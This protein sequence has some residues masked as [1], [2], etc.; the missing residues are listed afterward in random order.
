MHNKSRREAMSI[1]C[2]TLAGS[3]VW[4]VTWAAGAGPPAQPPR[5]IEREQAL[6]SRYAYV[7]EDI[8]KI[9]QPARGCWIDLGAG[10]GGVALA[11]IAATGNPV[12]M[13]DPDREALQQ[14]LAQAREGKM[15]DRLLAVVGTAEALPLPDN[16]VDLLAS[17]GSI[18]FW[19]DPVQGLREVHRVLRPGGVAY[20]GGGAGSGYPADAV[21]RLIAERKA[22][23]EGEDAEKWQRFVALRRPAQ[24]REWAEAAGLEGFDVLGSGA[25]SADDPRVGQG[26]W[27]LF[28][29]QP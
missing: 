14:G 11:L 25:I 27:L 22:Q 26:V 7:A 20:I 24:M 17:R 13:I 18:F 12:L 4:L 21:A 1:R 28:R 6:P 15:A 29:K 5:G 16:A 9:C 2:V 8:L 19:R 23:L 10:E 3:L